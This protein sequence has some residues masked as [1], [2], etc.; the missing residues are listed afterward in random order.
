MFHQPL[1]ELVAAGPRPAAGE[2]LWTAMSRDIMSGGGITQDPV[3]QAS[4][5]ANRPGF[6]S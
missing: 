6:M 2:R 5:G 1:E 4:A 3:E